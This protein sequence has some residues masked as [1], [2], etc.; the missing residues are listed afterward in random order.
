MRSWAGGDYGFWNLSSARFMLPFSSAFVGIGLMFVLAPIPVK[1]IN[2][3]R[4]VLAERMRKT[5]WRV[6]VFGDGMNEHLAST[7]TCANTS[8][9]QSCPSSEWLSSLAGKPRCLSASRM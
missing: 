8:Y 7:I 5:D 9:T 1:I 2:A 6:E 3:G 4:K